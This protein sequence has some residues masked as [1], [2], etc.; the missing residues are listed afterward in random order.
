MRALEV[1]WAP[2][3]AAGYDSEKALD[4]TYARI[5]GDGAAGVAQAFGNASRVVKADYRSDYAYHAQ[6]EPLN[7][8]A[9]FNAAGTQVEV[10]EGTQSP[11][12]SRARIARA[13]GFGTKQVIHHQHYLGGGFGR[14]SMTDYTV[15]A[16]LIARAVERPVKLIWTREQDIAYGMFRPQTLQKIEAALGRDGKIA[17]WR[18]RIVGDGGWMTYSGIN[19]DAYYGIPAKDIDPVGASHGIRLRPWRAVAH[20]F[21]LFAIES[22]VDELAAKEG[23]DPIAFRRERMNLTP[24]AR[25]LFDMVEKMSDWSRKRPA[26]RA[27]GVAVSERSGSLGAGV[28]EISLDRKSGR[29]RVHEVWV[30]VDGG[31]I[32][33]PDMARANIESGVVWGLSSVLK[34]R[35]T[36][37]DGAVAQSNFHDY[38]L[39]RMSEAPEAIHVEFAPSTKTP[40]G[41]GEVGNPF[42][43]PAVANA[44]F[45]LT[46]KRLYHMPFTPAR[47][48]VALKA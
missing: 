47:V 35:L 18:H 2:G 8:V 29:I 43:G 25:R 3:R 34:E 31:T 12:R 1:K 42:I 48:K 39:L 22:T 17:G 45:A 19:L 14:R 32:V 38:Q 40:T 21:N 4:E 33:Q 36:I 23:M 41:I 27:L 26:G 46:G 15:E 11:G 5:A 44:F 37:K 28:V 24:K 20:P 10:W 6:M 16:A 9:R 30:A 7:A 13:L